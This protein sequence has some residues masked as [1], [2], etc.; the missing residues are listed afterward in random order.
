MT[1]SYNYTVR[2]TDGLGIEYYRARYYNL[3]TGRL[4]SEDPIGFGGGINRILN[5]KQKVQIVV[6]VIIVAMMFASTGY[7]YSLSH[8]SKR[9]CPTEVNKE[10]GN[11]YPLDEQTNMV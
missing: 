2:E 1:N 5:H 6:Q 7:F 4:L 8:Y 3:A 10:G 11:V 9:I